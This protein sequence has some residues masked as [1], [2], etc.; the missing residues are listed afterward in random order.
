M[1]EAVKHI[2][3]E[4]RS[5]ELVLRL[6]EDNG[7]IDD[8]DHVAGGNIHLISSEEE[9]KVIGEQLEAAKQAGIDVTAFQWL[10]EEDCQKVRWHDLAISAHV[11][12]FFPNST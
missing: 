4:Q 11:P 12:N 5:V 6:I 9:R 8:V 7:W 1:Q 10:T 2:V 3:Q